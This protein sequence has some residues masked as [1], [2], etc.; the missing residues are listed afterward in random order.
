M[1][2]LFDALV[3]MEL[4]HWRAIISVVNMGEYPTAVQLV[5]VLTRLNTGLCGDTPNN[6]NERCV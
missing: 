4:Y 5:V 6:P 3:R 2:V 1:G